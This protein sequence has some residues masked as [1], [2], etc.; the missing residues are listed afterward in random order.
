MQKVTLPFFCSLPVILFL[1]KTFLN[2]SVFAKE[3][4]SYWDIQSIDTMKLSRDLAREG[5]KDLSFE[6][7]IREQVKKIADL[8]ATHI[9]LGTPYDE[10]FLPFLRKWVKEAR[11]EGL[12]V[13]FRGNFSGWE[14]WFGYPR[15]KVEEH[16]QKTREFILS[17][18]DLFADGDIFTACTECENGALGDPRQT[19]DLLGFRNFLIELNNTSSSAFRSIEKNVT[20]NFFPMNLDV[21]FLVMD[22]ETTMA[23][24]KV[25]VI[26]HYVKDPQ[27]LLEDIRKISEETGAKVLLGEFGAPIPDIHGNMTDLE[28]AEWVGRALAFL[29]KE[30]SLLGLNYWVA[31]GGT[32]SIWNQDGREKPVARVLK[33]Y[34]SPRVIW[35]KVVDQLGNP[36]QGAKIT[37]GTKKVFSLRE[38]EFVLAVVPSVEGFVVEKEGYESVDISLENFSGQIVL[39]KSKQNLFFKIQ[40]LIHGFFLRIRNLITIKNPSLKAKTKLV[41]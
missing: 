2:F 25:V 8:G 28:Q 16:L 18:P 5:L 21:A 10:E 40:N 26:D 39:K 24:G 19:K 3:N 6:V 36:V 27:K 22:K 38:G 33:N 1:A 20:T 7:V 32:T 29:S 35:G 4:T 30:Q 17:N 12:K 15:I 31:T 13:W 11:K 14:G 9:A 34:F 37:A 41:G 23:L